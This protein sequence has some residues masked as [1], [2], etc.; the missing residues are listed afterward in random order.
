MCFL[1]TRDR[2][3]VQTPTWSWKQFD[4]IADRRQIVSQIDYL[5]E[6]INLHYAIMYLMFHSIYVFS[7]LAA[8]E[9]WYKVYDCTAG[10]AHTPCLP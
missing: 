2:V 6:H 7:N 9:F 8:L 1:G 10:M 3:L 4:V 5:I